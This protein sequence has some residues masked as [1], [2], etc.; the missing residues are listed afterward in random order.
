MHDQQYLLVGSGNALHSIDLTLPSDKQTVKT[1]IQG[2]AFKEIHC[3]ED[4]GLVVV[5]A[6]RN[7]RVRCYDYDS[8]KRLVTYGHSKEGQGRVVEGGKLGAMKNM[9]Q[10]RVET[11]ISREENQNNNE[12]PNISP[13]GQSIGSRFF[14][15]SSPSTTPQP[16]QQQL[17]RH[18]HTHSADR[19]SL[20][21]PP[22]RSEN[23]GT[24]FDY[25]GSGGETS[26][27]NSDGP[28]AAIKK[29]KQRPLSFAGLASLAQE[30]MRNKAQSP[31]PLQSLQPGNQQSSS[32]GLK[33]TSPTSPPIST[34]NRRLSQMASYLSQ[35]AVNSNMAAHMTAGQDVP[36]GEAVD[37]AW[38]F[39]KLKQTKDVLAL[40]FHYTPSTVYMTVLSK[41]GI[42][43]YCRPKA[44]RGRKLKQSSIA[45]A[46]PSGYGSNPDDNRRSII[47]PGGSTSRDS[48]SIIRD[49]PNSYEW[50]IHK[51]FYHP[52][53]PSFMAVVKDS[54]EVTDIILGKGAMACVVNVK[55]MS[56]N[57]LHRLSNSG[58]GGSG[59]NG[60]HGLGKKLGFKNSPLWHSFEK[61][62]F[63]VPPYILYPE[64][65]AAIY[66]ARGDTKERYRGQESDTSSIPSDYGRRSRD[67]IMQR[68][69]AQHNIHTKQ[70]EEQERA[71]ADIIALK[72]QQSQLLG[73]NNASSSNSS[74]SSSLTSTL[75]QQPNVI[76]PA[77][78]HSSNIS[79]GTSN[80]NGNGAKASQKARMVTSDEVLNMAFCQRTTTQL[81]LATYGSQ[82]RIV[83]I[84]GKPQSPIV[85][86][87][88][89]SP[90][91][92]VEF[93]KTNQ[94]IYA[95]G[96]EKSSI[97]AFSLTRA[98]KVKEISKQD[99]IQAA[100]AAATA[101]VI[102]TT[103]GSEATGNR[104]N[105]MSVYENNQALA[106]TTVPSRSLS[107][108][109]ANAGANSSSI[110]FL[111]RDNIADGSLGIF[112][113][114]CHPRN[115]TSICKLVTV[116]TAQDDLELIGYY[117]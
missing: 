75:V 90:P 16:Q 17:N 14:K 74:S 79:N 104:G 20:L 82:S 64:A 55:T 37:W 116:P 10:L 85:L 66:D 76:V 15:G 70:V 26:D 1:H 86:D 72:L 57:D 53:A 54:Q 107:V 114:Y 18:Q 29:N 113:S 60:I 23:L 80:G 109:T 21:S 94:D 115:G 44:A 33:G 102:T 28:A 30:H 101:T 89:S 68:P 42:D 13:A 110:K 62:P 92:K 34:R 24:N 50:K 84:Q 38:D 22:L 99:L 36:S 41:T 58:N 35:A 97:V 46:A 40:D 100:D 106:S 43:I 105:R 71:E 81:F 59:G 103:G 61:I 39:T 65:A 19:S 8:I 6:G 31:P 96:F 45:V 49:N 4:I 95:V 91:Q 3:L 7:S 32:H 67:D 98:K 73:V 2:L 112:F 27:S 48:L 83:D 5:I 111:G 12:S 25:R 51:Q 11:V 63:D 78:N 87:W 93:L 108:N 52:E 117:H 9:I 77:P 88:E 56:V 47:S 69:S